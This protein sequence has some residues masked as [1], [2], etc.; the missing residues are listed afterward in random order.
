MP[1]VRFGSA[2]VEAKTPHPTPFTHVVRLLSLSQVRV[3]A[4]RGSRT[5]TRSTV[6]L[7]AAAATG[8]NATASNAGSPRAAGPGDGS[9]SAEVDATTIFDRTLRGDSSAGEGIGITSASK[10]TAAGR[11]ARTPHGFAATVGAF[12]NGGTAATAVAR[13]AALTDGALLQQQEVDYGT[14]AHREAVTRGGAR[15]SDAEAA[16]AAAAESSAIAAAAEAAAELARQRDP[17]WK[18]RQ[19]VDD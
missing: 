10:T 18:Y 15:A 7:L 8:A 3:N 13:G 2:K 5:L 9:G 12:N 11:P 14:V 16:A 17:L 19:Q 4:L 6:D 1:V